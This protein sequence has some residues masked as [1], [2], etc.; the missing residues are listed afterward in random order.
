MAL[1]QEGARE[2]WELLTPPHPT[3]SVPVHRHTRPDTHTQTQTPRY[4]RPLHTHTHTHTPLCREDTAGQASS[5][6]CGLTLRESWGIPITGQRS[7]L[8]LLASP[9]SKSSPPRPES[10]YSPMKRLLGGAT[11]PGFPGGASGKEPACQYRRR[12]AGSISWSGRFPGGGHGNFLQYSCLENPMDRGAW[13]AAV[14][15]VTQSW[16]QLKQISIHICYLSS[17]QER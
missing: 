4:T 14:H 3:Q 9:G 10:V 15:K 17:P 16:T 1:P 13:W 6:G 7:C 12:D 11:C 2:L 8:F 5:F